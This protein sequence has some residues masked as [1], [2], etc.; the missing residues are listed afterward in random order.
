MGLQPIMHCLKSIY[1]KYPQFRPVDK[2]FMARFESFD[3]TQNLFACEQKEQ[4]KKLETMMV[5][6]KEFYQNRKVDVEAIIPPSRGT[7]MANVVHVILENAVLFAILLP[8]GWW[9]FKSIFWPFFS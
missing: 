4:T 3:V 6:R 5:E 1:I 2:K 9:L 7:K 8:I